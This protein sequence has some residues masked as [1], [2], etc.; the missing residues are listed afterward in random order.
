MEE[1][2]E[3][4]QQGGAHRAVL[5]A[6][7]DAAVVKWVPL[8]V[9]DPSL[10]S[11]HPGVLRVHPACLE[12]SAVSLWKQQRRLSTYLMDGQH[13]EGPAAAGTLCHHG[14]EAGID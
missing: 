14:N 8:D 3:P 6:R 2:L 10:V 4:G 12:V 1:D 7:S 11:T 13:Q 9:Q 5:R